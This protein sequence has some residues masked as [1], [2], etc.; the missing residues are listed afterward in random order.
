MPTTRSRLTAEQR[1]GAERQRAERRPRP[2]SNAGTT[3][4]PTTAP[5]T[6]ALA[7]MSKP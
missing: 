7:T 5:T 6:Y 3:T 4:A 2:V 1:G